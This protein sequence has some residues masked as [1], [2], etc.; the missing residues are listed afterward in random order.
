M[1]WAGVAEDPRTARA[2]GVYTVSWPRM[3]GFD[4]AAARRR[5]DGDDQLALDLL[6]EHPD[7]RC[8]R[9]G[10][11]Q[12]RSRPRGHRAHCGRR[13]PRGSYLDRRPDALRLH[14]SRRGRGGLGVE[15]DAPLRSDLD[16]LAD[17]LPRPPGAGGESVD[18]AA[19]VSLAAGLRGEPGPGPAGRRD[20]RDVLPGRPL[21]AT[22]PRLRRAAGRPP[23]TCP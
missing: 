17:R 21:H 11:D 15:P 23:S 14:D 19:P 7:R 5:A 4:R 1:A 2:I 6:R 13:P 8:D 16:R 20:V 10:R 18:A 3:A 9:A 22:H 12:A